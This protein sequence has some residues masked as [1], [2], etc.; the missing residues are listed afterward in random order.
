MHP[1]PA[2]PRS[3]SFIIDQAAAA[4]NQN[5]N[6]EQLTSDVLDGIKAL[7]TRPAPAPR[8]TP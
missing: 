1:L 7:G 5:I 6:I 2:T 8:W 3:R 4:V